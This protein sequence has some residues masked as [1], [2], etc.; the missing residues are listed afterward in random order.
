MRD[1]VACQVL[2]KVACFDNVLSKLVRRKIIDELVPVA[3]AADFVPGSMNVT[4]QLRKL[5][6]NPAKNEERTARLMFLHQ[7]E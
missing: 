2:Q 5:F 6:G 1:R 7:G 4:D 3:V